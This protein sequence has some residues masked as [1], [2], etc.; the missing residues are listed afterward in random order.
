MLRASALAFGLALVV[1]GGSSAE[2]V[3]RGV[4]D[5]MLALG[6]TGRRTS[7]T[8]AGTKVVVSTRNGK[9]RWRAANISSAAAG[10]KVMAFAVGARGPVAL[11]QS[12]DGRKLFLVRR[13]TVGWQTI[14]LDGNLPAG[15]PGSAGRASRST[16]KGLPVVAYT[17]WNST[18]FG[19]RLLLVGVD[20]RG[21]IASRR[22][23][24]EG[25]PQSFVPPPAVPVFVARARRRG[26][27]LRL[28][29]VS[30]GRSSG[31]RTSAPGPA[32][33]SP[34]GSATSPS[35]RCS[36]STTAP[37]RIYAAWTES[38]LRIG[39]APVALAQRGT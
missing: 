3:A 33:S 6:A 2:I 13:I 11:V 4:Q 8:S 14:R 23:T 36:P 27:V 19:S 9:G 24:L 20:A 15:V 30:S 5:G 25:F 28:Q 35:A 31:T 29:R 22:I 1:A 38:M 39:D 32:S 37:E 10:S 34:R 18:T 21:R 17:R 7:R 26:R 16:G 12:A